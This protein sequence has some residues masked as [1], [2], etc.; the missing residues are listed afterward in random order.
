MQQIV[1]D[2]LRPSQLLVQGPQQETNSMK[3]AM[4][5]EPLVLK[6]KCFLPFDT[7]LHVNIEAKNHGVL[8]LHCRLQLP[9]RN[10]W[11]EGGWNVFAFEL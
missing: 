3:L 11:L 2:L 8:C 4:V 10:L 5:E 6:S 7:K 1:T 9:C